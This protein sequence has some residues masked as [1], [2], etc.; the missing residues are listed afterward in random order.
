MKIL[1]FIGLLFL[2][3]LTWAEPEPGVPF[4]KGWKILHDKPHHTVEY[5]ENLQQ[6]P[7]CAFSCILKEDYQ[8]RFAPEC[9]LRQGKELGKCLCEADAY[10][11]IVD[12]CVSWYCSPTERQKVRLLFSAL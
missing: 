3:A 11:Y 5:L 8:L 7:N 1:S 9:R 12:Q 4:F 6:T 2:A 10:Q